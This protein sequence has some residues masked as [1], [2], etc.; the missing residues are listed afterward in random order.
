MS[1]TKRLGLRKQNSKNADKDFE[2]RECSCTIS[3][4]KISEDTVHFARNRSSYTISRHIPIG[5][6]FSLHRYKFIHVTLA[7]VQKQQ[8]YGST[9]EQKIN[10]WYF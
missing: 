4:S 1:Q 5:L 8:I 9:G 7:R 2:K 10:I 6:Y 3:W